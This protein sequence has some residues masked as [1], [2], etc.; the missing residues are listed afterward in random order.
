MYEEPLSSSQYKTMKSVTRAT[1]VRD[2]YDLRSQ[3]IMIPRNTE[4]SVLEI[5]PQAQIGKIEYEGRVG[6]FKLHDFVSK[7]NSTSQMYQSNNDSINLSL[8][9]ATEAKVKPSRTTDKKSKKSFRGMPPGN[10]NAAA[11]PHRSHQ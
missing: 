7:D 9:M 3:Q 10:A 2:S 5:L 1:A 11:A 4:V 6:I 8:Q